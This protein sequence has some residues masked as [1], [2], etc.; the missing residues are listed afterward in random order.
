MDDSFRNRLQ[1]Y[2]DNPQYLYLLIALVLLLANGAISLK[3]ERL[4]WL[5]DISFGI[6]IFLGPFYASQSYASFIRHFALGIVLFMFYEC[7]LSN[8]YWGTIVIPI[9]MFTFFCLLFH[10]V[11]NNVWRQAVIS[12]NTLL[13][14]IC[15]YLILGIMSG[16]IFKL[17]DLLIPNSFSLKGDDNFFN[18]IYFSFI[19]LTSIGFGDIVP[20]DAIS[21]MTT[22]LLSVS[23]QI[24]ITVIMALIVGKYVAHHGN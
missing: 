3:F 12:F 1:G 13:S 18:F 20:L 23:G 22:V 6:V 24:Y 5:R 2:F 7:S 8:T 16:F 14:V 19:T 21:K 9:M 10:K 11:I 17:I 4:S 15:G